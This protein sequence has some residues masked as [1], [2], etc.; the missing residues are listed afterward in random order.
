MVV[1][2][3]DYSVFRLDLSRSE[4]AL[5]GA[6]AAGVPLGEAVAAGVRELRQSRREKSVFRAFRIWVAEGMFSA[7]DRAP[8]VAAATASGAR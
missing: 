8:A 2:R 5:L 6:I 4:R 7:I 3:R 1:Y